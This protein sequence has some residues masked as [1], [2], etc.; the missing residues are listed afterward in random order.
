[1]ELQQLTLFNIWLLLV[2]GA[3]RISLAVVVVLAAL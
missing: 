1:V 3:G 2:V